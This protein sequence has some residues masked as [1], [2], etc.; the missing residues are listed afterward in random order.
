MNTLKVYNHLLVLEIILF[1]SAFVFT[2][3]SLLNGEMTNFLVCLLSC[4]ALCFNI[5]S[6]SRGIEEETRRLNKEMKPEKYTGKE[7]PWEKLQEYC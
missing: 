5:A 2:A 6:I 1:V 7:R 4:I 3:I